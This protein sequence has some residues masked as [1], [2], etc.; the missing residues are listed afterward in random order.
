MVHKPAVHPPCPAEA[1]ALGVL[2]LPGTCW[3]TQGCFREMTL[4]LQWSGTLRSCNF[5]NALLVW[6][7]GACI[8]IWC[9]G[10]ASCMK[11]IK[12]FPSS[13]VHLCTSLIWCLSATLM[14]FERFSHKWSKDFQRVAL[15]LAT[16][17]WQHILPMLWP[18]ICRKNFQEIWSTWNS[19]YF[20]KF[21]FCL[22]HS[23]LSCLMC[24]PKRL[25][26][27]WEVVAFVGNNSINEPVYSIWLW[28]PPKK[29]DTWL[30][31]LDPWR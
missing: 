25:N 5:W 6:T 2:H 27:P 18:T 11:K 3:L 17:F 30:L 1:E 31:F 10:K 8:S 14:Y 21:L 4:W 7:V 19:Y 22:G 13:L 29:M 23:N 26:K 28:K 16:T 12:G 15:G 24:W 20:C 9:I